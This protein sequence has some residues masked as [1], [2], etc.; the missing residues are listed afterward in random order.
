MRTKVASFFIFFQELSNKK[1]IKA[2]RP[3]MTKIASRGGGP[4]LTRYNPLEGPRFFPLSAVKNCHLLSAP[5]AVNS[6]H[7]IAI[8]SL[9]MVCASSIVATRKPQ[10]TLR[11]GFV[12][13]SCCGVRSLSCDAM[14]LQ[15]HVRPRRRQRKGVSRFIFITF[16]VIIGR[17]LRFKSLAD[18]I[19]C[20]LASV[21]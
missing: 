16:A 7:L 12:L 10:V 19:Y 18:I 5:F 15:V 11:P 14:Q 13:R 21:P 9:S 2:L 3:K 4:A 17:R 6:R 1:K 8:P 20:L